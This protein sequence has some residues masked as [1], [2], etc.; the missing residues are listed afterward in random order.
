LGDASVPPVIADSGV[1]IALNRW[2]RGTL[3]FRLFNNNVVPSTSSVLT[4]FQT[5]TFPG[6]ADLD[7]SAVPAAVIDLSG[8]GV[9]QGPPMI[10]TR[11]AGPGSETIY[12]WV[13]FTDDGAG[14]QVLGAG[15]LSSPM[16]ISIVGESVLLTP[17]YY[18][19]R[20]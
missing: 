10:W 5:A 15:L 2:L 20:G 13:C 8:R 16:P 4:D 17:F 19:Q 12:G 11:G 9:V 1:R 18:M 7:G 3:V 6:Y 14:N